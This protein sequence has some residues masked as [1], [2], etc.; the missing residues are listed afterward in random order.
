LHASAMPSPPTPPILHRIRLVLFSALSSQ[1]DIPR[2][3][4]LQLLLFSLQLSFLCTLF[5][6]TALAPHGTSASHDCNALFICT[7]CRSISVFLTPFPSPRYLRSLR[8]V[9][10]GAF[11]LAP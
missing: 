6:N 11:S 2:R 3:T 8:H 1:P 7:R 10:I 5:Y 9:Y 4:S